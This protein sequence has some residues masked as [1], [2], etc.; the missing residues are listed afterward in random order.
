MRV[1]HQKSASEAKKY[2]SASDYYENGPEQLKGVWFGKGAELLGLDGFVDQTHFDRLA[3]NLHPFENKRLTQRNHAQR[4]VLTDVT[5][6]CPKSVSVFYGITE[7]SRIADAVQQAALETLSDLE[8]DAQTRVNH[9]RGHLTYKPTKNIVGAA[10]LHLTGRPEDDPVYGVHPDMQLHVHGAVLNCTF[11]SGKNRWTAVDLSN[12]VRDSGYYEALFQSRLAT[13]MKNLGFAVERSEHNFEVVGIGRETIEKFS[14]RSSEIN[15]LVAAGVAHKIAATEKISIDEAKGQLGQRSRK[16]KASDYEVY[17]LPEIWRG[18]L[19]DEE[20][21]QIEEISR[22]NIKIAK[23]KVTKK[24]AVDFATKHRF[25]KESVTRERHLLRDALM[26]GMGDV[27]AEEIQY[28]LA[29][30]KWIREGEGADALLSTYEVLKEEQALLKFVRNGRGSVK[31]L[32]PDH[33]IQRD[34]LSDEQQQAVNGLLSSTERVQI[35]SGAAGVGKTSLMQEAIEGIEQAGASVTVLAPTAEAAHDVLR[36]KEGFDAHT[37]ASFLVDERTQESVR[38]GVIWVDEAG[39]AGTRDVAKLCRIADELDARIILSGDKRQHKPVA[40]GAP[41]R[42]LENQVGIV[43]HEV[44]KIRRQS[45]DYR[46]AV[47]HLSRG[48]VEEGFNRL[49][50]LG[51]VHEIQGDDRNQALAK[52]YADNLDAGKETL[53]IAPTHAEREIVTDAIRE[54]LK[55][56]GHIHDQEHTVS[57]LK[58]RRLSE[59]E[60]E[61]AFNY[62]QDDMIEF[63]RRGKGGFKAGDRLRVVSIEGDQVV[64]ESNKG[65]VQVP[66]SS[67]KSFDVYRCHDIQ[68]AAGDTLRITKKNTAQKLYNGT[69]VSLEGFTRDGQLKLSN[70]KTLALDWGHFDHGIT[71]TSHASQGKTYDRVLVAQSSE[72]FPASSPEQIYVTAS[73][74]KERVDIYSDNVEGLRRSIQRSQLPQ[75]SSDLAQSK[76]AKQSM[77]QKATELRLRTQR[78]VAQHIERLQ[79]WLKAEQ[80]IQH[81]R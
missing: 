76:A 3:D 68:L 36:A 67:P 24:T 58:S 35:L 33:K 42:L 55:K 17:E 32:A 47:A 43:P 26:Q 49:D 81:A 70:G 30:R 25:E 45:G 60:R 23:P 78:L 34:W 20:T 22:G 62:A 66:I 1:F 56:R 48:E 2:Y 31:P 7:D 79:H 18:R 15:K 74:G 38:D 52:A 12:A 19:T 63:V 39:L 40:A 8:L 64:A 41:L 4:R 54:E 53:V 51:Y 80:N 65:Y 14:R 69:T 21:K 59:A 72:S 27:S 28:E 29:S 5:F 61:D 46:E 37:L 50:A 11:D 16:S 71:V 6:S 57:V 10:W 13:K 75:N 77:I 9:K 44:T 73:R